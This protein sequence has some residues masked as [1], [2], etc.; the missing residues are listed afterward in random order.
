MTTKKKLSRGR[1]ER[2]LSS[3]GADINR[4]PRDEI[5]QARRSFADDPEL[6][7]AAAEV[8]G[9]D[10]LLDM[11]QVQVPSSTLRRATAEIPLR[12]PRLSTRP[13]KTMVIP[14]PLRTWQ[15]TVLGLLAGAM[16][17]IMGLRPATAP[18]LP[19]DVVQI[20][21]STAHNSRTEDTG[22]LEELASL[23]FADDFAFTDDSNLTDFE[24][25]STL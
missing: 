25:A 8:A 14:F 17:V 2:L 13:P 23:A 5:N 16:G 1:A 22:D 9:L 24:G 10:L 11:S 15:A 19:E 6:Q 18:G 12:H 20:G 3:Y 4:Y 7:S 21:N